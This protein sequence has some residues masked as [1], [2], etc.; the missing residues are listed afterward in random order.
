MEAT[1][2]IS[3]RSTMREVLEAYFH[4]IG[5]ALRGE[6]L[7]SRDFSQRV[8]QRLAQERTVLA[9]PRSAVKRITAYALSVAASLS[10]IALAG[11][12][13]FFNN[14]LTPQP[15]IAKA[16]NTPPPAA[17]PSIRLASVPSDGRMN[18]YLIAHQEFSPS[19]AILGVAPY[20]RSVSGAQPV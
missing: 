18:E 1:A 11:W 14:P 19:T 9:P 16:P 5:V 15:E 2:R 12:I 6:Y 8:T 13:A 17:A 3:E 7:P 20:L 10:A 4:L